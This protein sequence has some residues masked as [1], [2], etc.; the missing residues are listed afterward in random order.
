[1]CRGRKYNRRF[2][3]N[4]Y[5]KHEWMCGCPVKK[6]VFCFPCI[7]FGGEPAWTKTGVTDLS[8][9]NVY[10]KRHENSQIHISNSMN[11]AVLGKTSIQNYFSDAYRKSVIEHNEKVSNNRYIL[12]VII[13]CIRFCGIFSLPLRGH[14]ESESSSNPGVFR[15]LINFTAELDKSLK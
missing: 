14:D 12:G 11:L 2:Q 8:H 4:I 3:T 5:T 15:G 13:N 6:A 7:L 9:L 1:M 10:A